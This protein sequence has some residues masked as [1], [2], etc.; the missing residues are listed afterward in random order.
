MQ[1]LMSLA[2]FC[3]IFILGANSLMADEE[4]SPSLFAKDPSVNMF[5]VINSPSSASRGPDS[6]LTFNFQGESAVFFGA[7][8]NL[9]GLRD[10][11]CNPKRPRHVLVSRSVDNVA[12]GFLIF[13]E[14]GRIIHTLPF[15]T[16]AGR[17]ISLAFDHSGNF[18]VAED[19]SL[20]PTI[21]KNDMPLASL[22]F[23]GIHYRTHSIT[24]SEMDI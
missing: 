4:F 14:S 22:P 24:H 2:L 8:H 13:N 19:N 20:Q 10:I 18:Y 21:F 12:V 23:T 1:K 5:F 3:V 17:N 7:E 15:G 6:I 16:P 9:E 11:A